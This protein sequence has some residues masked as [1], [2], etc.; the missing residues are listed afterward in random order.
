MDGSI[1]PTFLFLFFLRFP[2]SLLLFI[3][4]HF[5]CIEE[6]AGDKPF[7]CRHCGKIYRWK[8]TLRRH[9]TV[10]CGGKAPSY[11]CPYCTYKAKQRGN[12][13]VHVRKHH[14]ELPQLES[15]RKK[16]SK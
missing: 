1:F 3:L 10:E 7:E 8:S 4:Y 16:Q 5:I 15:R 13:G 11:Q 9:E 6:N 14:P 12:L 2:F